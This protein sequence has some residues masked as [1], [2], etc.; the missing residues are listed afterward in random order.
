MGSERLGYGKPLP[1]VTLSRGYWLGRTEV[2][3]AQWNAVMDGPTSSDAAAAARWGERPV[4]GVSYLQALEFCR[5]LSE[6]EWDAGRLPIDHQFTLPSEAQWEYA[7]RAGTKGDFAGAVTAMAWCR[8]TGRG[9]QAVA[10]K[11][12]N[13]WGLYDM[14]GNV[15]EWCRDRYGEYPAGPVMDP[16]GAEVGDEW[17]YRGGSAEDTALRCGSANRFSTV[18]ASRMDNLG[19]RIALVPIR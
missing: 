6:R 16:R 2:T 4:A 3:Q 9:P 19:F 8:A 15:A 18:A 12:A 7:C 17:V 1:V 5:K 14:H 13:A 11:Q 10:T